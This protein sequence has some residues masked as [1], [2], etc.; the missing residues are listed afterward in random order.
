MRPALPLLVAL[1]VFSASAPVRAASPDPDPDP[2]LGPDKALH[3]GI[4]ALLAGSAYG[5]SALVLDARYERLLVGGGFALAAGAAKELYDLSGHGDP[6][7]RDFTWDAIGTFV[8]LAIAWG[9][10]LAVAGVG[11]RH[12]LFGAPVSG[13]TVPSG[14]A[15]R[16]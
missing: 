9:I 11:D 4:S 10:D 16:F 13:S 12:P 8:G 14:L 6:S 3:F 2:W 7:W 1:S 15:I 5:L